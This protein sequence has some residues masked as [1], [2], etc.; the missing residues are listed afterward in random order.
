MNGWTPTIPLK[1]RL[2]NLIEQIPQEYRNDIV[3][4]C[5]DENP[6]TTER[7]LSGVI[8]RKSWEMLDLHPVDMAQAVEREIDSRVNADLLSRRRSQIL[9]A[10]QEEPL[11]AEQANELINELAEIETKSQEVVDPTGLGWFDFESIKEVQF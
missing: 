9:A 11:T 4:Q 8:L 5:V 2:T 1:T 6:Y 3:A 7:N 10:F